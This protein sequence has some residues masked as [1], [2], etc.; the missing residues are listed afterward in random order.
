MTLRRALTRLEA[1][2][3]AAKAGEWARVHL[4]VAAAAA[5]RDVPGVWQR[6]RTSPD[7]ADVV[8]D[9]PMQLTGAALTAALGRRL[10]LA[11]ALVE[12]EGGRDAVGVFL[13][14]VICQAGPQ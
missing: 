12:R 8:T 3:P 2:T 4:P 6:V 13:G 7:W 11:A 10:E 5:L 9:L 1:H 14:A